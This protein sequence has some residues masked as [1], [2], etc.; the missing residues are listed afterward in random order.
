MASAVYHI[1]QELNARIF[2]QKQRSE[3]EIVKIIIQEIH[4]R[5]N[6]YNKLRGVLARLNYYPSQL[7]VDIEGTKQM[8]DEAV[9]AQAFVLGPWMN[10]GATKGQKIQFI[11]QQS[12]SNYQYIELS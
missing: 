10:E 11:I 4:H 12:R 8:R 6:M 5:G 9:E 1:W 3:D 2:K 7:I